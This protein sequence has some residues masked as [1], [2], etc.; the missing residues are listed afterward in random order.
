MVKIPCNESG[1]QR[2][3]INNSQW[4]LT[5][6]IRYNQKQYGAY[7]LRGQA[8][9][10]NSQKYLKIIVNLNFVHTWTKI[11]GDESERWVCF[12]KGQNYEF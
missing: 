11:N 8:L 10:Y 5:Y 6:Y 1:L 9:T 12:L 4:Y 3:I 7:T 2:A